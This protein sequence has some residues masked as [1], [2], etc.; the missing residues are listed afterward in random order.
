GAFVPTAGV[1]RAGDLALPVED[2]SA[3]LDPAAHDHVPVDAEEILAQQARLADLLQRANR[4]CFPGYRH[5]RRT[6]TTGLRSAPCRTCSSPRTIASGQGL[7]LAARGAPKG[8]RGLG[9]V[10]SGLRRRASLVRGL[11]GGGAGGVPAVR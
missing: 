1:E 4:L 10:L 2:V 3:L 7:G 9:R 11:R 6:L 5:G 8:A